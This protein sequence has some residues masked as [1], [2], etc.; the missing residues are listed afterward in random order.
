MKGPGGQPG[1]HGMPAFPEPFLISRGKGS[2]MSSLS[3]GSRS[4]HVDCGLSGSGSKSGG[5]FQAKVRGHWGFAWARKV[6]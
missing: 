5:E 3:S 4:A 2:H 6:W 1:G